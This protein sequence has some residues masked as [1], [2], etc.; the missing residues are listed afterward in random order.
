MLDSLR[1]L[2]MGSSI[3]ALSL[4]AIVAGVDLIAGVRSLA[5]QA[6]GGE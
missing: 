1:K 5:S 4:L 2:P 6:P 3:V